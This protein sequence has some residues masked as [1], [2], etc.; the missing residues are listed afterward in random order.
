MGLMIDT[1]VGEAFT[2]GLDSLKAKA[3]A[4]LPAPEPGEE[5][6]EAAPG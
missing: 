1:M 6:G 4:A 3:E 2:K 5:E